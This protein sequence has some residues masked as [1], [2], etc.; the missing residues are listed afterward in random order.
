MMG[1]SLLNNERGQMGGKGKLA[2]SV[3]VA[4]FIVSIIVAVL[5]PVAINALEDPSES[6]ITQSVGETV[7]VTAGLNS[8]LDS[9]GTSNATYTLQTD[10]GESQT[11][12]IDEGQNATFSF[13]DG[14]VVVT[15]DNVDDAN[16]TATSTFEY[17]TEFGWGSGASS[18]WTLLGLITVLG[19]FFVVLSLSLAVMRK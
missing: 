13:Q 12:T 8:T 9:T 1:E 6:T 17:P 5:A 14:D 7:D 4:V 19:V 18:L 16:G 10:N 11:Q 2:V 3:I 15:V